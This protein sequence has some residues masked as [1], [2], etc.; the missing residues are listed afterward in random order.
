MRAF[1]LLCVAF[2]IVFGAAAEV[3][4]RPLTYCVG[5]YTGTPPSVQAA[6]DSPSVRSQHDEWHRHFWVTNGQECMVCYDE[7]DRSCRTDFTNNNPGWWPATAYK[8]RRRQPFSDGVSVFEHL[9]G[10][11]VISS[12]RPRRTHPSEQTSGARPRPA[13]SDGTASARP[14]PAPSSDPVVQPPPIPPAELVPALQ[15]ITPGPYA[16]GDSVSVRGTVSD[17]TVER[18]SAGGVFEV[19]DGDQLVGTVI[20]TPQRDGSIRADVAL[21]SADSV[22]VRFVPTAPQM[23]PGDTLSNASSD[24]MVLTVDTCAFRARVI[25][26]LPGEALASGQ[27]VT[28]EAALFDRDDQVPQPMIGAD[29]RFAV[30]VDG[31]P[32]VILS[33]DADGIA[34]WTPPVAATPTRVEVFASGNTNGNIICPSSP[35]TAQFSDLGLGFDTTALPDTCYTD[36]PCSG[37]VLLQRPA[38]GGARQRVDQLLANPATQ[39][40]AFDGSVELSRQRATQ[41]DRYRIEQPFNEP[42]GAEWHIEIQGPD[43]TIVMPGHTVIVRPALELRLPQ[44]LDFGV[45]PAGSSV[46]DACTD[47]DFSLSEAAEEHRWEILLTGV[48][49]C[50]GE[51]VLAAT[52]GGRVR[53]YSLTEALTVDALDPDNP[54]MTLCL[55]TPRCGGEVSP[56]GVELHVRPLT[57]VFAGQA[58]SV[59]LTW[60]VTGRAWWRCHLWWVLPIGGALTAL[61]LVMGVI[62]PARFPADATVKVAGREKDLK[63]LPAVPLRDSPGSGAGFYRDARLGISIAGDINGSTRN[64]AVILRASRGGSVSLFG[65]TPV[66]MK[67]RKGKWVDVEDLATGH[68]PGSAV[69]RVGE[70]L[71]FK[72]DAG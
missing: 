34:Q 29:I 57:P 36:M 44:T 31:H 27:T 7:V 20:G 64:A 17:G 38:P 54:A 35:L 49:D 52:V 58:T 43:G 22:R 66:Q 28:L 15:V 11:E 25:A 42:R 30:A 67:T 71:Y 62:R 13:P 5:G 55:D 59:T 72:V 47:L 37:E 24:P 48:E 23:N 45:V 56:G 8:C 41:T 3:H 40:V 6:C 32:P 12:P 51:P 69:Y 26:P 63:R 33:A 21:P 50:L 61:W 2:I 16:V 4:A 65:N 14:R 46:E 60:E 18:G 53:T 9:I 10:G 68:L 19:Y 39:V 70:N 1:H